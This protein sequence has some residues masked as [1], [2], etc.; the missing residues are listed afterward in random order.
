MKELAEYL[1]NKLPCSC[2][3]LIKFFCILPDKEDMSAIRRYNLTILSYY[4]FNEESLYFPL[5]YQKGITYLYN[6]IFFTGYYKQEKDGSDI[7]YNSIYFG[8]S[9]LIPD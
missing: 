7:S 8:F 5:N 2:R 1:K 4:L 6:K 3:D 9:D